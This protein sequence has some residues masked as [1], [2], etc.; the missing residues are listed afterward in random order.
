SSLPTNYESSQLSKNED[1]DLDSTVHKPRLTVT[2]HEKE[3][4]EYDEPISTA[5]HDKELN[6]V[7]PRLDILNKDMGVNRVDDD[8]LKM[9]AR[10]LEEKLETF[11]ITIKNLE[12]TPGPVVT[13]YEFVPGDGIKVSRI[14]GLSDD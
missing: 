9:N 2:V 4:P 10:I 6:Y 8:E 13:Q 12:V 3:L 5:I 14:E 7:F 11:K 1:D